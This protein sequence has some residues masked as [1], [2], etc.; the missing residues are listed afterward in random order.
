M[1][2]FSHDVHLATFDMLWR[3][4]GA[5]ESSLSEPETNRETK[6]IF[7]WP[8]ALIYMILRNCRLIHNA[9][10]ECHAFDLKTLDN[11]AI[12]ALVE[13]KW[14]TI[15]L[16]FWLFR[17]L[18]Q[19][20]FYVLVLTAVFMQIYRND[21]KQGMAGVFIAI[22]VTSSLFLWLEF[23]QVLDDKRRYFSSI[24]NAIDLFAFVLPLI[25]GLKELFW[26]NSDGY[27]AC[28]SFSVPFIL[29]HLLRVIRM[30]CQFV[31]II[32]QAL[33]SIR[34]FI[35]VF[36]GGIVAFAIAI[37]HLLHSCTNAGDCPTYTEGFSLNMLQGLSM[38]FFMMGGRYDPLSNAFNTNDAGFHIM[39]AVFFFFTVILM[40]NVLIALIN[41]AF[42]DGDQTWQLDWL[43]N[44]L[45]YIESAENL[46]YDIPATPVQVRDYEKETQ[47][48]LEESMLTPISQAKDGQDQQDH[49][50]ISSGNGLS[51]AFM[52][53]YQEDQ[54][55]RDEEDQDRRDEE[56]RRRDEEQRR[57]DEE[58]RRRCEEQEKMIAEL[59]DEV[60]AWKSQLRQ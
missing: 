51:T 42:D 56:Q 60:R 8:I 10:I 33:A 48:L 46:T 22:I 47:R 9:T 18:S 57:R 28:L 11:P 36:F 30:V 3:R 29:L 4:A 55:R 34:V 20:V 14:N 24:Y 25:G 21:E 23:I 26:V 44:R 52:K 58:Q 35:F 50:D 27:N 40:L 32:I 45:R 6:G 13:Y 31:S 16:Y 38:T 17:F 7:S 41:H 49:L 19:C 53:Q 15:G 1:S 37:M 39:M 2:E 43:Q 59:R 54:D 5:T 12:A